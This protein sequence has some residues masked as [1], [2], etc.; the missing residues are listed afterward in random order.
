MDTDTPQWFWT[1]ISLT[2]VLII[3][4]F[5]GEGLLALAG[6]IVVAALIT[7][8]QQEKKREKPPFRLGGHAPV[9]VSHY[10]DVPAGAV[11][12][13]PYPASH[14]EFQGWPGGL[15]TGL[16]P[17]HLSHRQFAKSQL[18]NRRE[19]M[20]GYGWNMSML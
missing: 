9:R 12:V 17:S 16:G 8:Q 11:P 10:L 5:K 14:Q 13:Y 1:A 7:Y 19:S 4:A 15:L 18:S 3:L 20:V 2:P 6:T